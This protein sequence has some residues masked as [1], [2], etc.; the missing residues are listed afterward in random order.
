MEITNPMKAKIITIMLLLGSDFSLGIT[1]GFII[2]KIGV[3]FFTSIAVFSLFN[4]NSL[5]IFLDIRYSDSILEYLLR[6]KSDLIF[7]FLSLKTAKLS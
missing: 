4:A 3:F 6:N 7:I 5:Y 1:T 2:V